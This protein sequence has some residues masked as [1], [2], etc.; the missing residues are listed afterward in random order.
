MADLLSYALCSVSDVKELLGIASS[1]TSKDNLIKRKINQAT[2]LIEGYTGRRFK[3]TTYTDEVYDGSGTRELVLRNYPVSNLTLKG[4]DGS[5][6]NPSTSTVDTSQY[7]IDANSG[8][9]KALSS[10]YGTYDR[11]LVTYTAGYTTIPYDLQE[12]CATLAAHL[13]GNI[14]STDS[15]QTVK[16]K[17]E[18][19]RSVEYFDSTSNTANS[20]ADL[21]IDDTLDRYKRYVP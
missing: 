1:D 9:L 15:G 11:W 2:E 21:G 13:V 20:F 3:S 12:A 19:S 4:R 10:F 17:T 16:R 14:T 8:I 5:E 7:F 18:G 6:N